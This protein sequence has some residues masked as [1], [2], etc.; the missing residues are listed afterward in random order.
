MINVVYETDKLVV[1]IKPKNI[2]SQSES[3]KAMPALLKSQLNCDIFP[4]HRLD[5]VVSGL[6]VYAK[7]QQTAAYLSKQITDD[8]FTKEYLAVCHGT[9]EENEAT[10]VDLLFHDKNKNKS[11]VVDKKRNGVK[12]A[13]LEYKVLEV[14]DA[15]SLVKINL[16]TGRTH[17]IRVQ[18]ASRKHPLLGDGKYGS[19]DNHCTCALISHKLSFYHPKNKDKLSF[20][21]LPEPLEYPFDKFS[22][23]E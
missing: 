16:I 4:V 13:E 9:I 11:Y 10:L 23:Y 21:Y 20:T 7:D 1:C 19:K 5:Q 3:P 14:K 8:V 6:I 18:F 22:N 12:R 17:Q 2:A 15:C